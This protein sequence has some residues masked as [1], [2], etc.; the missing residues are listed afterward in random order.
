MFWEFYKS[1]NK[2]QSDWRSTEMS[3]RKQC[4]YETKDWREN[5][6]EIKTY[7]SWFSVE[8][9]R[10]QRFISILQCQQTN[11]AMRDSFSVCQLSV[12]YFQNNS[13]N[14]LKIILILKMKSSRWQA[15]GLICN[16]KRRELHRKILIALTIFTVIW[17]FRTGKGNNTFKRK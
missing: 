13:L 3:K 2:L 12:L 10:C 14:T 5:A 4:K 9:N 8:R 16:L 17:V 1:A 11:K 7:S 6:P 15:Y